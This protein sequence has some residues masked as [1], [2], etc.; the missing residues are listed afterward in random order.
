MAKRAVEFSFTG[1][2]TPYSTYDST[3]TVLGDL[4]YQYTGSNPTDKFAGPGKIGVARPNETST[5]VP[6]VFPHVVSWADKNGFYTT[7][8]VAVSGTAV[9][10]S[11]TG[12]F[13]DGVPIGAR[14]GFGS[15]NNA[16]ITTWYTIT[17]INSNTSIT[18]QSTAGTI[19]AGTSFIIDKTYQKDWVF[20]AD[21]ATAAATRRITMFEYDRTTSL[22]SWKGFVTL[23]YPAGGGN[24]TIRGLRV[25]YDTYTTGTIAV[26][27]ATVTGTSTTWSADRIAVGSRI[28]FG[29]T[30]PTQIT[31]WYYIN[32]VGSDTSITIQTNVTAS[33]T[34]GTAASLTVSSGTSYVIEDL[35]VLTATTAVV[36]AAGG[37]AV[38]SGLSRDDFVVGGTT[39]AAATTV[40]KSKAVYCLVDLDTLYNTGTASATA[41]T[42]IAGSGTAWA[43]AT[44]LGCMIGFGSTNPSLI[45][46]WYTITAVA[47]GTSLTI[48]SAVTVSGAYVIVGGNG[49]AGGVAIDDRVSWTQQY[50]Y[51]VEVQAAT[52]P[53]V[54]KYNF[55]AN[56]TT[57]GGVAGGKSACAFTL[58]T[59]IQTVVGNTSQTNNGRV[60]ILSHG[61]GSGVKCLY[62]ATTSRICRAPLTSITSGSIN[63]IADSMTEVPTGGTGTYA[64]AGGV[65]AV[66][67][68]DQIDRLIVTSVATGGTTSHHRSYI[69]KYDSSGSYVFDH[70]F[71][72]DTAQQDQS[73]ADSSSVA[74]PNPQ[75]AVLTVWSQGGL[76]YMARTGTASTTN[77]VYAVP[78]G[79]D[80]SY[81]TGTVKQRLVTPAMSTTNAVKL[82]KVFVNNASYLGSGGLTMPTEPLRIYYRTSGIS[83]DSGTWTLVDQTGDLSG[84]LAGTQ[85][86]F[87]IEFRL[88]GTFCL[89]SRVYN[90]CCT[91]EDNT[92]DSHY[93][94]SVAQSS[95]SSK[96]FAWRFSAVFGSIVPTLRIRLY[97]AVTDGLLLDDTTTDAASGTWEKSTDGGSSW[98]AYDTSDKTNETTY[99]RYTP[100]TL[101][102]NI[103]VRAL[104]TQN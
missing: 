50:C 17:A 63:W 39:I 43:A 53:Q 51:I 4:I 98:S 68:A 97:N 2:T 83:D 48:S 72:A 56:L 28:G 62:F 74:H 10:G 91:Y 102:D 20:L 47:S 15:T 44:H 5:A 31:T 89:P 33:G 71:L 3:K 54:Y 82:S 65:T 11:G 104:L 67:I 25:V 96:I 1:A 29:S 66:E 88:I 46:T 21:N 37:L 99:I 38:V 42:T 13:T 90:I 8:T 9:T 41:S 49:I 6:G 27:G 16:S 52:T 57:L 75:G 45:T 86:Q 92:T 79:A 60:G 36:I 59:G 12:W 80:W 32:A 14:I 19:T 24:Q 30:D 58:S 7:G 61:S 69:T 78:L 55:R 103:K 64:A 95:V 34:G 101:G 84:A 81:A 100:T 85:V 76:V 23:T 26:S 93:Q 73:T 40:D 35:R 94:P 87:A 77:I 22:F 18:I 70:I